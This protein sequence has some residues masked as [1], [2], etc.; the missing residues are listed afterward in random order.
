VACEWPE[1]LDWVGLRGCGGRW[2]RLDLMMKFAT[3]F[4]SLCIQSLDD[5]TQDR[6][7]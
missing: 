6:L 4:S 7:M 2:S 5:M 1:W 3:N